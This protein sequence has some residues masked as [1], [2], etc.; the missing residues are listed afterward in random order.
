VTTPTF[1]RLRPRTAT[2]GDAGSTLHDSEGK[3]ALFS[4]NSPEVELPSSGSVSVECS[5]CGECTV[6]SPFAAL[7]AVVPSLVLSVGLGRRDSE[8]TIGLVRRHHG[9]LMRCPACGRGSWTR[10]TVR[11]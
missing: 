1:D 6:M 10:I 9:A 7:R 3:R 8:S 11:V 5:R 4:S 2:S